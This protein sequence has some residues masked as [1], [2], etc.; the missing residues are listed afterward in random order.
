MRAMSMVTL[1]L[2]WLTAQ[3]AGC[4]CSLEARAPVTPPAPVRRAPAKSAEDLPPAPCKVSPLR[5]D[6]A[7]L[8][9]AEGRT[10]RFFGA[11]TFHSHL[12]WSLRLEYEDASA[13]LRG[14]AERGFN[15]VRVPL[16]MSH[17]QPARGVFPDN[18]RY[19]AEMTKHNLDPGWIEFLDWLVDYAGGLGVYVLLEFHELPTD[20]YRYFA[21]GDPEARAEKR[22]GGGVAWMSEDAVLKGEPQA[23][24][25]IVDAHGWL[26]AHFRGKAALAGIE[27][28]FNEPY[29]EW[30]SRPQNYRQAAVSCARAIKQ[31]DPSRLVFLGCDG[32]GAGNLNP[33]CTWDVPEEVD[34]VVPHFYLVLHAPVRLRGDHWTLKDT[35]HAY[36]VGAFAWALPFTACRVPVLLGEFGE[37]AGDL[38]VFDPEAQEALT[39]ARIVDHTIAQGL[40]AGLQGFCHWA[41][42]THD[43]S[44]TRA[45]LR[46]YAAFLQ[47]SAALPRGGQPE[48]VLIVRASGSATA[49]GILQGLG[50]ITDVLLGAQVTSVRL[51]RDDEMK[52]AR[53][54]KDV[55][56]G[57]LMDGA[58]AIL[59][60]QD[61]DS[62][63]LD[64][65]IEQANEKVYRCDFRRPEAD[66]LYDHL[67][68]GGV[69]LNRKSP[70]GILFCL[71]TEGLMLYNRYSSGGEVKV[72]PRLN[73][74]GR[75]SLCEAGS[76]K[77]VFNGDAGGLYERGAVVTVRKW[78]VTVLTFGP[79]QPADE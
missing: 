9:D 52:A 57:E 74:E 72:Y 76:G 62:G 54:R 11:N 24:Q 68:A 10:M 59:V 22:P 79:Y 43:G 33:T 3:G 13:A 21:G 26:A 61:V 20:P 41:W 37:A 40:A 42:G 35:D 77:L 67:L 58:K 73:R 7:V 2:M 30:W 46:E 27:V 51:V 8:N 34:A 23:L 38:K 39:A 1:V 12:N 18:P 16:N 4:G 70:P 60:D 36:S 55:A 45:A 44:G 31:A 19:A 75:F 29:D 15:L 78:Q 48:V 5:R 6:G 32:W 50:P 69:A 49:G 53:G 64:G 25:A 71:A 66:P 17:L 56:L 14:M 63:E 65:L 28:P 47:P